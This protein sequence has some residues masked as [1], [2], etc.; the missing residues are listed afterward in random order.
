MVKVMESNQQR[1]VPVLCSW[2][3]P[4]PHS[5]TQKSEYIWSFLYFSFQSGPAKVSFKV[6]AVSRKVSES[7][8]FNRLIYLLYCY[9]FFKF[10]KKKKEVAP[11]SGINYLERK[12]CLI[13]GPNSPV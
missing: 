10:P 3:L 2:L 5:S 9:F 1:Q 12:A 13:F 7:E 11:A 6:P 4:S 8:N